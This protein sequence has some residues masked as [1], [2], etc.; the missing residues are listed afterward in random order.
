MSGLLKDVW[1]PI[2]ASAF[3]LLQYMLLIEGNEENLASRTYV[4]G[5]GGLICCFSGS[6]GYFSLIKQQNSVSFLKI[7][8]NVEAEALS[9]T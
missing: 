8:Y 9:A 2:P 4:V 7:S 5:R 1:T 6:S 3:T